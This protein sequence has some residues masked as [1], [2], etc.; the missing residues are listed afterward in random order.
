MIGFVALVGVVVAGMEM[1]IGAG[2]AGAVEML[3]P[4]CVALFSS[5]EAFER[6]F[7]PVSN[8][9]KDNKQ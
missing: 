5:P 9:R 1:G 2:A 6:E 7:G 3:R 4:I 8:P